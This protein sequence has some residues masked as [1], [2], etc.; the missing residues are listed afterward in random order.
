VEISVGDR[1]DLE[2]GVASM[3]VEVDHGIKL[4]GCSFLA[5]KSLI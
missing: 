2:R 1:M 4:G 5:H 3:G